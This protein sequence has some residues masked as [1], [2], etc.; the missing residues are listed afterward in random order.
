MIYGARETLR[1]I[2]EPF[3]R[4]MSSEGG[5]K[6]PI[7]DAALVMPSPSPS[8]L[9]LVVKESDDASIGHERSADEPLQSSDRVICVADVHGN[10]TQLKALW[11]ALTTHLGGEAELRRTRVVFL[12]D[13]CDRGPDTRGVLDWLVALK[14]E[15][16]QAGCAPAHFLLGNH[17]LGFAAFLGCLP[18]D[19]QP[20]AEWLDATL[21][22]SYTEGFWKHPVDGGMHYQGRRWGAM[23]TYC[24]ASTFKSYGVATSFATPPRMREDLLAAV[25]QAHRDFLQQLQ[26]VH[27]QPVAWAPGQLICVHAGLD[28]TQPAAAQLGPLLARDLTAKVLHENGD[29]GRVAALSGRKNVLPLPAE[30]CGRS[31][32]VSGHHGFCDLSHGCSERIV[33]DRGGGVPSHPLDA[34]VLPERTVVSSDGSITEGKG[35]G[36]E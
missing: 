11:A 18:V 14:Q 4:Y 9:E 34:V 3:D 17:D 8:Q 5:Q 21:D 2:A 25:P 23:R 6:M 27:K 35:A 30:L 29:A 36:A 19:T 32:L 10:L 31:L 13:Y 16:T 20:S 7:P 1:E 15:R 26:W 24:S 28:E 22:P 33:M 12:G